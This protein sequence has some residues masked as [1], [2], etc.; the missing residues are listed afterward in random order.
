MEQTDIEKNKKE[1]ITFLSSIDREGIDDL[2]KWLEN[3]DF[4][5]APASTKYHL[6]QQGGLAQH[7]LNVYKIF[8]EFIQLFKLN[9]PDPTIITCGLLHDTHKIGVYTKSKETNFSFVENIPLGDGEKSVI[10]LLQ[11]I[12]LTDEEILAIRWHNGLYDVGYGSRLHYETSI[13]KYPLTLLLHC[14]DM[15]ASRITEG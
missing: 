12:S 3:S 2:L 11:F 13:K 14:A 1:I 15:C 6:N 4:F 5:T 10:L 8:K 9:V 7:S